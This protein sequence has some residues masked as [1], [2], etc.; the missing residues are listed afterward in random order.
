MSYEEELTDMESTFKATNNSLLGCKGFKINV[1]M[2]IE[3]K[4]S[5]TD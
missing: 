1:F 4:G 5:I 3:A 2:F